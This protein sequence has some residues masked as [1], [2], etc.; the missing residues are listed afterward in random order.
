MAGRVAPYVDNTG[1]VFA[2]DLANIARSYLGKPATNFYTNGD[3]TG[4]TGVTQEGGSNPTNTIVELEN[5]GNSPYVLRQNGNFTE[6]QINLTSQLSSNTTYVMSGWYAESP[7]YNGNSMMFHSRAFSASGNHVALDVGLYNV[8]RTKVVGGLTWK[9]CYATITTPSDYNNDFN[10]YV[11]YGQ[12]SHTGYRYYTNLQME[13]GSTPSQ[14]VDGTRSATQ[15]LKDLTGR[16]TID[17]SNV[18]FDSSA[19]MTFDGTDDKIHGITAVHSHLSSSAIEFVVTPESTGKKMTVGGYRHNEG[20][21]SPTIG[22]VYIDSNNKFYASVITAAEVYRFVESTT[23]IQANRTYHVVFNKDTSAGVMQ[24][25]VNG[26]AEGAQTFNVATY[27]QWSSAGSYIGS[28]TIDL[29]KSFNTNSGQGWSGDF[30]DGKIHTFKMFSKT[31]TASEIQQN[32]NAVRGRY[33]I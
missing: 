5:P 21:S 18:S 22:M 30:L 25:Y 12:P 8:V 24:L 23:T 26:V 19:Q 17:L 27:A 16:S 20:Y 15:G 1:L 14:F 28:D 11:G 33:G 3:F 7:E 13:V 2:Y 32:F 9:Y 31:L 4:G 6:Y 29:G 10:W